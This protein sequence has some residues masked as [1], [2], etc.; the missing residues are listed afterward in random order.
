[1]IKRLL[2]L[3][4][5]FA[6]LFS[7]S[8]VPLLASES[9]DYLESGA[10]P[11]RVYEKPLNALSDVT[12][13]VSNCDNIKSMI[14]SSAESVEEIL[15]DEGET[16]I[17]FVGKK[18][19]NNAAVT[20]VPNTL[21]QAPIR[22][23]DYEYDELA[24]RFQFYISDPA[25]I[26]A[27][28]QIE[29][30]SSGHSDDEEIH[31]LGKYAFQHLKAG[32]NSIYLPFSA[33]SETRGPI[34]IESINYMRM[35]LFLSEDELIA[36][37]DIEIVPLIE[38]DLHEDFSSSEALAAWQSNTPLSVADGVLRTDIEGEFS[39]ATSSY[40]L[41]IVN[42]SFTGI[43]FY[44][45][46]DDFVTLKDT[47]MVLLDENGNSAVATL[48]TSGVN[49]MTYTL[50]RVVPS[51]MQMEDGFNP[52][53]TTSLHFYTKT[54]ESATLY[55]DSIQ[56]NVYDNVLWRDWDY[57]YQAEPGA[58]S[59]A[60]LPDIQMLSIAYPD[61]LQTIMNWVT[62]NQEKE[63]IL[64]TISV[65]DV[66]YDGNYG[67][68]SANAVKN[69][70]NARTAF[71]TLEQAAM[72]YSIAYGNHDYYV[73]G[74]TR[75]TSMFNHYFPYDYFASQDS[76]GGAQESGCSDNLY[77]YV[78]AGKVSYLILA[79]EYNADQDTL[80][81]AN[82]IVAAH[83]DH[84]VIVTVHDYLD[85]DGT[86]LESGRNLWNNLLKKHENILMLICGHEWSDE[87]SGSLVCRSD[88]GD[89]GNT[90]Y[91]VM[92]NAQWLDETLGGV[93][94]LLMLRFSEDGNLIDFNYFSPVSGYAYKQSNQ[95]TLDIRGTDSVKIDAEGGQVFCTS[96]E[97]TLVTEQT[98]YASY[99][100]QSIP[101]VDGKIVLPAKNK[102]C[103]LVL[104]N[105]F[106][107]F[108]TL[109]ITVNDGHTGG[110]A[111]CQSQAIC[112]VCGESYGELGEHAYDENGQC[113]LCNH[114]KGREPADNL[115]QAFNL[116]RTSLI[117]LVIS[118]AIILGA[119]V[120]IVI[121]L[122]KK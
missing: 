8:T 42:P 112:R 50:L 87:D 71:D 55:I 32:W 108:K 93:G 33:A 110:N 17:A 95:F 103:N 20:I 48:D 77:Y 68:D 122:K 70:D 41:P 16:F 24:L 97:L 105:A 11:D 13:T 101:V 38:S 51:E 7:S 1:M 19:V 3:L 54:A 46:T 57:E 100:G 30:T 10:L 117:I 118:G 96:P 2:P 84:T 91:Q 9:S 99:A 39:L 75:D 85:G 90:V 52:A 86:R 92:A 63:N 67:W 58:Y 64:F 56:Y 121:L 14:F 34:N 88:E 6:L 113:M 82:E 102:Q 31:W 15:S 21:Q 43:E 12:Y 29:L 59:I 106:G 22:I 116:D 69:Y 65:G 114:V 76:F 26:K 74:G 60:V 119:A 53:R 18:A 28:A 104:S 49:P 27:G 78:N 109:T 66:T 62:E 80:D 4:C 111:T 72:E 61:K 73:G 120:A 83:P 36:V 23:S 98:V 81:W 107:R 94:M 5:I 40:H 44:V 45:K 37:D 25:S 115:N 79:L 89:H 35:Y 47:Q